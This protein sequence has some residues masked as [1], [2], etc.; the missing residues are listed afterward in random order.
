MPSDNQ[1]AFTTN[2][3]MAAIA[4]CFCLVLRICLKRENKRMEDAQESAA[5]EEELVEARSKIRF[6]L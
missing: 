1:L 6:V 2:T 4:V 5:T 3:I